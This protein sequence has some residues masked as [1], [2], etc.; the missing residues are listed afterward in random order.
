MCQSLLFMQKRTRGA[1]ILYKALLKASLLRVDTSC[2]NVSFTTYA[3]QLALAASSAGLYAQNITVTFPLDRPSFQ[4]HGEALIRS[5]V[6]SSRDLCVYVAENTHN[7][8]NI[9]Q[10]RSASTLVACGLF[11]SSFVACWIVGAEGVGCSES[12]KHSLRRQSSIWHP[13]GRWNQNRS[14]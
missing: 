14:F 2:A 8:R 3:S 4:K 12:H 6:G 7:Y 11:L 5:D 10:C 1:G 13:S 9:P